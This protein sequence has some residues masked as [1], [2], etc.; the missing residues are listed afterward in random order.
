MIFGLNMLYLVSSIEV[1]DISAKIKA[2]QF[3]S[4]QLSFCKCSL[5]MSQHFLVMNEFKVG[6]VVVL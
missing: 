1:S 2:N 4:F 5:I 3:L 6:T